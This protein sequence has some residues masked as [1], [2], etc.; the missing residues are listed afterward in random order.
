MAIYRNKAHPDEVV[1]CYDDGCEL[2]VAD[3]ISSALEYCEDACCDD[4]CGCC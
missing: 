1:V 3:T 4:A 2:F